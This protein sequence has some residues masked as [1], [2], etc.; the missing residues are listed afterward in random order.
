MISIIIPVYNEALTIR[1]LLIFLINNSSTELI[2]EILVVDGGSSDQTC[3]I[4]DKVALENPIINRLSSQKGRAIQMNAGAD[5]ASGP[6]LYFLHADSYPPIHYDELILKEIDKGNLAGCFKMKFDHHH[7]WLRLASWF[8]KFKWRA[9]RGGD[10]SLFIKKKLF[11][12]IGGY[13]EEFVIYEDQE[14][15]KELF[16][17]NEFVVI[18]EWITT[19]ARLYDQI[20]IWELQYHF[21]SIYIKRWFGASAIDIYRYYLKHVSR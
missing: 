17:R 11:H 6:I 14:F 1:K 2:S 12:D 5:N 4:I 13:N 18:Q 16:K 8:T 9:C 19:S 7:W 20:G 3:N 21:W 15:I 10:Q